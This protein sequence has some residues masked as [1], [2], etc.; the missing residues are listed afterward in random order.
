MEFT[1]VTL[2]ENTTTVTLYFLIAAISNHLFNRVTKGRKLESYQ[3]RKY[4]INRC[5]RQPKT[6]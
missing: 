4:T 6:V 5:H 3:I 1:N 2:E